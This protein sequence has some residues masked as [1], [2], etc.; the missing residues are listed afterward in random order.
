MIYLIDIPQ[1]DYPPHMTVPQNK[2]YIRNNF[3]SIAVGH[4]AVEALFDKRRKPILEP[5]FELVF[6][7]D[8]TIKIKAFIKNLGS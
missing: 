3:Q 4:A 5:E 8:T 6:L 7:N 1:S 2:Y